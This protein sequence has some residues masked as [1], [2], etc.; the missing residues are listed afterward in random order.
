VP[1][2]SFASAL[3]V[4]FKNLNGMPSAK[5]LG[6]QLEHRIDGRGSARLHHRVIG[7]IIYTIPYAFIVILITMGRYHSEQTEAARSLRRHA[8]AAFWDIE[9]PQI[10]AGMFSACAF[11]VILTFNEY[12]RTSL[13][14]GGFDTFTTV[15]V[16][17]MLNTGMSEQSYAMGGIVS[18]VAMVTIGSII[19]ITFIQ[20]DRLE[21]RQRAVAEP[22]GATP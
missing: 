7:L 11:T 2:T 19:V 15:L 17:Q 13:L 14:K 8:L 5:W 21:K 4:Y 20:Q 9:F 6:D 18:A 22:A 10:R 1:P 12:V 3:L 16:S